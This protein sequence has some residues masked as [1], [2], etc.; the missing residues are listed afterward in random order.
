MT[1]Q[2]PT[3]PSEIDAATYWEALSERL[4]GQLYSLVE[5]AH[6]FPGAIKGHY[7]YTGAVI[8]AA[9]CAAVTAGRVD[10]L[11]HSA[12]VY[13]EDCVQ[14]L[15]TYC[16][17]ENQLCLTSQ[18]SALYWK[19]QLAYVYAALRALDDSGH[20][21]KADIVRPRLGAALG[22]LV[23]EG[24]PI[25][26][27]GGAQ[28]RAIMPAFWYEWLLRLAPT[29]ARKQN[30]R[31][32]VEKIWQR[33]WQATDDTPVSVRTG[34][35]D[36]QEDDS[37]YC[38]LDLKLLDAW[39]QLRGVDWASTP[40]GANLWQH[41]AENIGNDGTVIAYGDGGHHGEY[42]AGVY[43]A[44][45]AG[46]RLR[47]GHLISLAHRALWRGA[48]TP[49]RLYA[50]RADLALAYLVYDD[51]VPDIA[52]SVGPT[53]TR[54]RVRLAL[55]YRGPHIETD[56]YFLTYRAVQASKVV[57][58]SSGTI[59]GQTLVFHTADLG[60]HAENNTGDILYYGVEGSQLLTRGACREDK[61][62]V[63]HN[64]LVLVPST[65]TYG[66][67]LPCDDRDR[68][69]L[70]RFK[71]RPW[72][73]AEWAS[74]RVDLPRLGGL[75]DASYARL[76]VTHRP[77]ADLSLAAWHDVENKYDGATRLAIGYQNW[78]VALDRSVL[79]VHDCCT[80]VRDRV[81]FTP[82]SDSTVDEPVSA[83]VGQNWMIGTVAGQGSDWVDSAI[84]TLYHTKIP[85][86]PSKDDQ[87]VT[88]GDRRLLLRFVGL[89]A[90]Q[91]QSMQLVPLAERGCYPDYRNLQTR[92]WAPLKDAWHPN[93][94]PL[95]FATLLVPHLPDADATALAAS[96]TTLRH[97]KD[98]TVIQM[99]TE[100]NRLFAAIQNTAASL[101][102]GPILTDAEAVVVTLRRSGL[103]GHVSVFHATDV[104]L[105]STG[106]TL[107]SRQTP[108]DLTLDFPG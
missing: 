102:V 66:K 73:A 29:S 48:R 97:D 13:A 34:L 35:R 30:L 44:T 7:S 52:P 47:D 82:F 23:D 1:W 57:F 27:E 9:A 87:P 33:Y 90:A 89:Q 70:L 61:S 84:T 98:A 92:A 59:A 81:T 60:G 69:E 54:R 50:G 103:G 42:A 3:D 11:S 41:Y 91:R 4:P 22:K 94:S 5:E 38:A 25:W 46:S 86:G 75:D 107:A 105:A 43:L 18:I 8:C 56:S 79:F 21:A 49:Q 68:G 20:K 95:A 53:V 78:P 26:S 2:V 19:S 96:I 85:G 72:R 10:P 14:L 37:N 93:Q 40:G 28:N 45:L 101:A 76:S 83:V 39:C 88:V 65:Y 24:L 63:F 99:I 12:D 104:R 16:D 58:R 15:L 71:D 64:C 36:V 108:T 6:R 67:D 80:L 32:Y 106:E 55:P 51:T 62:A 74:E 77:D 31:P 100:P 17:Y